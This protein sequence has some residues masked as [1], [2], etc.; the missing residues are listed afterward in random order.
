M[1]KIVKDFLAKIKEQ[2]IEQLLGI[3]LDQ[4]YWTSV[5]GGSNIDKLRQ[6]LAAEKGKMVTNR[7]G[8]VHQDNRDMDRIAK[9][10]EDI[11]NLQKA[12]TEFTRLNQ[13][14]KGIIAYM[15]FVDKP[16]KEALADLEKVAKL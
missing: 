10:D 2:K 16:S 13:M 7:N 4:K 12:E 15:G 11:N 8:T 3:K 9:L 6:D 5:I 1:S 14:E